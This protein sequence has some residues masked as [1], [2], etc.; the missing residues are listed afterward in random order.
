MRVALVESRQAVGER[1]RSFITTIVI[2]I[3]KYFVLCVAL[4]LILA[5]TT[6]MEPTVLRHQ[7]QTQLPSNI[8]KALRSPL[9]LAKIEKVKA[10]LTTTSEPT[11]ITTPKPPRQH[12]PKT[13]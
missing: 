7:I 13:S 1:N 9:H 11:T 3:S 12:R 5:A 2:I 10:S 6:T 4:L 8:T